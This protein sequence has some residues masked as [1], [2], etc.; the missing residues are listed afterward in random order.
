MIPI[1]RVLLIP[2]SIILVASF[3]GV[4]VAQPAQSIRMQGG[5]AFDFEKPWQLAGSMRNWVNELQYASERVGLAGVIYITVEDQKSS[6]RALRR[7][8]DVSGPKEKGGELQLISGWP[9]FRSV[10][11][12]NIP[13]RHGPPSADTYIQRI[14]AVAAGKYFVTLELRQ[15]EKENAQLTS[16][17]DKVFDSLRFSTRGDPRAEE[18]ELE[19]VR[20]WREKFFSLDDGDFN[21]VI[22][23]A[24]LPIPPTGN[25]V[26]RLQPSAVVASGSGELEM[27]ASKD[28]KN[29]VIGTN[30]G[31]GFSNNSGSSFTKLGA[32]PFSFTTLGDPSAGLGATGAFYLAYV[33]QP[34]GSGGGA[35]NNFNGCTASVAASTDQGANWAFRGHARACKQILTNTDNC[36]PDQE[37]I[38]ADEQNLVPGRKLGRK[39]TSPADQVYA[40]WREFS[41][42]LAPN[43]PTTCNQIQNGDRGV[44]AACSTNGGRT[45]I[46]GF[47]PV[48]PAGASIDRAHIAVGRDGSVYLVSFAP[49]TSATGNYYDLYIDKFSSCLSGFDRQAGFPHRI[50]SA[51]TPAC[52]AGLDR[53]SDLTAPSIGISRDFADLVWIA[54]GVSTGSNNDDIRIAMSDNGGLNFFGWRNVNDSVPGHRY[55]P[56]ICVADKQIMVTWY[57]RRAATA[58]DN[59]L[60]DYYL[61]IVNLEPNGPKV[62]PNINVSR[63]AESQCS[64]GW[65]NL[66]TRAFLPGRSSMPEYLSSGVYVTELALNPRPIEG[67]S[68]STASIVGSELIDEVQRLVDRIPHAGTDSIGNDCAIAL[69]ELAAWISDVLARRADQLGNEASLPTARLAAAA[70][71][72]VRNRA[73]PQN[74]VLKRVCFFEG[75][76]LEDNDLNSELEAKR[77]HTSGFGTVNGFNID[78]RD[79]GGSSSVDVSPGY[80]VD[81]Y[82]R[83]IVLKEQIAL[84]LPTA[85]H[86]V[87]VIA[88]PKD[89]SSLSMVVL[90]SVKSEFLVVS[91][92]RDD[93]VVLGRLERSSKG[94]RNLNG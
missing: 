33:G 91:Q 21:H 61:G 85:G 84:R 86:C 47:P 14:L 55:S 72:L 28:G 9:A 71:A 87:S 29:V 63:A 49:R 52:F 22:N 34:T 48:T 59:S 57:D 1:Q 30:S 66:E 39:R 31:Y 35:G 2:I 18:P 15:Y 40:A 90:P 53:C 79:E 23:R 16:S 74:S 27:A 76:L 45:W 19:K 88:R 68:T 44:R 75:Q 8:L 94:W 26:T 6:E 81:G 43:G 41:G 73:Q 58:A 5:V 65:P 56:W 20:V 82:G 37:H 77:K 24:D 67:V 13:K 32:S 38:A 17:G 12:Q 93:D 70:L 51:Q 3:L 89:N 36:F 83:V 10:R 25:V 46:N 62:L 78:V 42:V 50:N 69:L 80:A 92:P 54:Y 4:S 60:T 64:T 11:E 7:L